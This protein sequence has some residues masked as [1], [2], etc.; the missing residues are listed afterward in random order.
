MYLQL[1]LLLLSHFEDCHC[2]IPKRKIQEVNSKL[3]QGVI[4]VSCVQNE[5]LK[6]NNQLGYSDEPVN[7][8]TQNYGLYYPK[9]YGTK[10]D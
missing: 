8:T 5:C 9:A 7:D 3:L 2:S 10:T 4:Y 6:G 1:I